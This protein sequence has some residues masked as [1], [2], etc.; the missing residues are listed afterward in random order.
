MSSPRGTRM[1]LLGIM[2]DALPPVLLPQPPKSGSLFANGG[3]QGAQFILK[4][5]TLQF[6]NGLL[7]FGF[8]KSTLVM[9]D[10]LPIVPLPQLPKSG[11]LTLMVDFKVHISFTNQKLHT[12]FVKFFL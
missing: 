5:S 8:A 2:K 10:E 12:G 11:S 4:S 7:Q 9:K 1:R 3:Y 6:T